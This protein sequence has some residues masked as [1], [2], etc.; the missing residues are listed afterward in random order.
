[1]IFCDRHIADT[2]LSCFFQ[3]F[4][5]PYG[6]DTYITDTAHR[7]RETARLIRHWQTVLPLR[8]MTLSYDALIHDFNNESRRLVDFLGLSWEPNC[9][10]FHLTQRPVRT[11]SW[12]QV[13]QPLYK[14]A[15]GHWHSYHAQLTG[16]LSPS[17]L[18]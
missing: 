18:V 7:F 17:E 6:F 1:M 8:M 5:N 13:R 2:C 14:N 4:S 16:L 11:A 12:S 15:S 9:E 3:N 10:A